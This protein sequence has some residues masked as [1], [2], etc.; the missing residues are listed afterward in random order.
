M[1]KNH[2]GYRVSGIKKRESG[3]KKRVIPGLTRNPGD[4]LCLP[5]FVP[6]CLVCLFW[7]NPHPHDTM[8]KL[9]IL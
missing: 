9:L 2:K 4:A 5:P 3:I 7:M 8:I 1:M 6:L